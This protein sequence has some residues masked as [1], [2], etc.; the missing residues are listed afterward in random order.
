M[1][2]KML[3][4]CLPSQSNV[5]GRRLPGYLDPEYRSQLTNRVL[6]NPNTAADSAA[7]AAEHEYVNDI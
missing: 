3:M 7:E 2:S 4:I 6:L 1:S 5:V